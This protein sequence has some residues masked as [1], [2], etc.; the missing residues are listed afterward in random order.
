MHL[1]SIGYMDTVLYPTIGKKGDV[2]SPYI[3]KLD[4]YAEKVRSVSS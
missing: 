3:G 4:I 1:K 2:L